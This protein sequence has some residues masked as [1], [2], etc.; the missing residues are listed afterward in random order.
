MK[1]GDEM[2]ILWGCVVVKFIND[3]FGFFYGIH[4]R[5]GDFVPKG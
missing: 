5:L 2:S 1:L 3:L 4:L